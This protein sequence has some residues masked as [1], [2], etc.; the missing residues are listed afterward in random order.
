MNR[1]F[2]WAIVFV[3]AILIFAGPF[4]WAVSF[5]RGLADRV[6]KQMRDQLIAEGKIEEAAQLSFGGKL[7]NIGLELSSE[8]LNRFYAADM[9][10]KFWWLWGLLVIGCSYGLFVVLGYISPTSRSQTVV[11]N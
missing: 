2:R 5:S 3:F 7:Q 9:L 10:W 1:Y 6:E 4:A 11:R 8:D